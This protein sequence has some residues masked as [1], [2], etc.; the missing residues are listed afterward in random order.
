ML[1]LFPAVVPAVR[2]ASTLLLRLFYMGP[3]AHI[4]SKI[5]SPV[6]LRM[7]CTASLAAVALACTSV[8]PEGA[9]GNASV[10]TCVAS[11]TGLLGFL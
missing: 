11:A 7:W 6:S 1:A 10:N 9:Y 2:L 8:R 4:P 3:R 5:A